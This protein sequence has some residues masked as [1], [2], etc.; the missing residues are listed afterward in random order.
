MKNKIFV[1]TPLPK[2]TLE[3]LN[4]NFDCTFNE[5]STISEGIKSAGIHKYKG[6]VT[7][8]SDRIDAQFFVENPTVKIIANYAV[9]YNNIDIQAASKNGVVVTNTPGVLTE[10]SADTAFAL[11]MATARKITKGSRLARSG[12]WRGWE[13]TQLLGTDIFGAHIGIVGLGRIGK[14]MARRAVGFNMKISY[15]NRTR[16]SKDEEEKT[17][18]HYLPLDELLQTVD[19][20]SLHVAYNKD[21]HQMINAERLSLMKSTAFI[22]N[23][24]R[25]AVIDE[26]ALIQ[27][28]EKGKIAGA[29]LDVFENEPF[30]PEA[31]RVLDNTVILPHLGSASL[32]TR[33]AMGELVIQNL[34][35]FFDNKKVTNPVN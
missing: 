33:L 19:F 15:W 30:I 25:G 10:T 16:L 20:V 29:G 8:L 1:A 18:L 6:I 28:L 35:A 27:C 5:F 17:G 32:K 13:P 31:L 11:L 23:T 12:Q 2:K 3:K 34:T 26:S 4:Q 22:I 9:G 24:A 7:L 21:T 14:A